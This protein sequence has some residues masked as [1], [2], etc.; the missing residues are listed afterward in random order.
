MNPIYLEVLGALVRWVLTA[1]GGYLVA[2]HILTADQT[3]RFSSDV[4]A[5]LVLWTPVIAALAWSIWAKLRQ[6]L[7]VSIALDLRPGST[8]A[9]VQHE[10]KN[11]TVGETLRGTLPALLL[12]IM[13]GALA[14]ACASMPVKTKALVS[15]QSVET[16]LGTAQDFERANYVALGENVPASDTLRRYCPATALADALHPSGQPLPANATVHQVVSC[17]FVQAFASQATSAKALQAWSAGTAPPSALGEL[18]GEADTIFGIVRGFSQN[19]N[20]QRMLA[21]AQST[22]DSVLDVMKWFGGGGPSTV[23]GQ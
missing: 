17:L 1:A 3:D 5:H 9:D 6:R 8:P 7:K 20:Q 14:T 11:T 2:H 13:L 19:V 16:A 10:M 21:L 15:L 4:L 23:P 12:A 22:V 18:R